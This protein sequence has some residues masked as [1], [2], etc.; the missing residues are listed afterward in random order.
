MKMLP[1]LLASGLLAACSSPSGDANM[2]VPATQPAPA[3]TAAMPVDAAASTTVSAN[4]IVESVD[5]GAK[6]ITIAHGPVEALKWPAMT[7]TFQ[8]PD[9]DLAL[10]KQGD[11]VAF[12]F[13]STGMK[14]TITKIV[15]QP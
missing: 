12:E 4:G 15:R 13:T 10:I 9:A 8:A 3:P 14:A 11:H 2:P 1:L 6:T 7:M 5:T